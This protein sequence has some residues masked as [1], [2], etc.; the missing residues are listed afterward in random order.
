M[1]FFK[2]VGK[3]IDD[4]GGP[5][6]LT[7]SGLLAQGSLSSYLA[8][9][10]YAR[11]KRVHYSLATTMQRLHF[12]NF[13]EN[14][15]DPVLKILVSAYPDHLSTKNEDHTSL[16]AS[17]PAELHEL[18]LKYEFYSKD[19]LRGEHGPTSQY[20]TMMYFKMI[21]THRK[22]TRAVRTADHCLYIQ[23]LPELIIL[24]FVFN[25]Q[26]YARWLT[27]Y[28]VHHNILFLLLKLIFFY[29]EGTTRIY[30]GGKR[31]SQVSL[32]CLKMA[33]F[34]FEERKRTFLEV[35][36]ISHWNK[37]KTLILLVLLV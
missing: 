28:C 20:W 34:Q 29:N 7:E 5:Y 25:H 4:S 13:L 26:N 24:F 23:L 3:F 21:D 32:P 14:L 35:Q 9:K 6:I 33:P 12:E 27:K 17:M 16:L 19:T 36:S 2:A 11:C 1:F 31:P 22:L 30:S 8:G 18:Y 37:L 10:N 15:N